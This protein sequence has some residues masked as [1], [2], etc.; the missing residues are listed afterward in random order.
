[1]RVVQ[2]IAPGAI[3]GA[4]S[5]V[6]GLGAGL[7]AAGHGTLIA[8]IVGGDGPHPFVEQARARAIPVEVIRSGKRRYLSEV[9]EIAS[10]LRR[11]A[12]TLLHTHGV[13]AD[14]V[15][16]WGAR[17]AGVPAVSTLH[18]FTDVAWIHDVALRLAHRRAAA[19]VAVSAEVAR[20]LRSRGLRPGRI[21]EIPNASLPGAQPVS[22][23]AARR[24]LGIPE[25][26]VVVGWVGRLSPEKGADVM[27]R[28]LARLDGNHI[29]LSVVGDGGLRPEL[30]ALAADLGV[31]DRVTWH[32]AVVEAARHL[33]AFDAVVLSSRTEGTPMVLLE[34]MAAEV[35]IVA[36]AVGGVPA[37]LSAAE[38][39]LVLPE[40]PDLLADA[41]RATLG[42]P[43]QALIRA[44]AARARLS[45]QFRADEWIEVHARLYHELIRP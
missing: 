43:A 1:M 5:V 15:G 9:R 28:A 11:S 16:S 24:A 18:G 30:A 31:A 37:M 21:R 12:A 29:H 6:L 7:M 10:L 25:D 3:G 17:S 32:G 35:P 19:V 39:L 40:R 34:A 2:L 38:A 4:E 22:R 45:A 42:D 20:R 44:R 41:I 33:A 26:R 36:T 14:I 13:H 27:L 8:A 23:N